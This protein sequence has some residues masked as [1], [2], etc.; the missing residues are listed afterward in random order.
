L[1]YTTE[2]LDRASG[3]L[4]TKS[5]GEWITVTE[6]GQA[7][8]EGPRQTR[9]ILKEMGLLAPEHFGPSGNVRNRLTPRAVAL[10]LGKRLHPKGGKY[11]FDVLSPSGQLWADERWTEASREVAAR[12]QDSPTKRL[13]KMRLEEF[14]KGRR[15]AMT[16]QMEICWLI[17]HFPDLSQSDVC[18]ILGV[19]KQT[20]SRYASLRSS[21]LTKARANKSAPQFDVERP[22]VKSLG[23]LINGQE[24][25]DGL[26]CD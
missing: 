15:T 11:P 13:A 1:E 26:V 5:L 22:F 17:D 2:A 6:Y 25:L 14:I 19:P 8:G 4:V 21:N 23:D 9:A 12:S 10:G 24:A 16:T 18:E 7:K 20:V 3:D